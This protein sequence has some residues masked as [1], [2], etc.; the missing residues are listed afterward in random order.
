[1]T[2]IRV[3]IA[4]IGNCA[5][6]LVQGLQYYGKSKQA[7]DCPGVNHVMLGGFHPSD[8]EVVA[9]FD[10]DNR[11][12]GKLLSE[13]IFEAPSEAP[14][15][16]SVPRS[17]TVVEKGPVMDGLGVYTSRVIRVSKEPDQDVAKRLTKT[18]SEILLN[19]LPSG[20]TKASQWYAGQA[21][22]AGCAFA[23]ATPNFIAS[24]NKWSERFEKAG[25]P[26]VG[27]DLIDQIGA[28]T[29]HK[30]L[31]Q[32]LS[33]NGVR[34]GETYQLDVGGGMESLDTLERTKE[35]KRTVKTKSVESSL[36]YKTDV[37][38]G[39]TDYVDFLGN[40]RDSYF[41]IKG[42]Y[43][44]DTPMQMDLKLSTVDG[45]NAGSVLF[46]VIRATKLA[47]E[48]GERGAVEAICAYSFKHPPKT[49]SLETAEKM[50]MEFIK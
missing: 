33:R 9:A 37:V 36:P 31:L 20:A 5:S 50:F 10:I 24:T 26:V 23:N 48:R 38:A 25:L 3:A 49:V 17:K 44:A 21:L 45:P 47:L 27:D 30:T 13:A 39:T 22:K 6:A 18:K 7:K 8:I 32:L 34:I 12:V 29:L 35:M 1:M 11:K 14:K 46:D 19:L 43:F 4:G 42:S 2:K 40:K 16:A 41:W 28:T 15:I